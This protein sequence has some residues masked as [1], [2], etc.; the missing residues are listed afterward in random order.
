MS[1]SGGVTDSELLHAIL[2]GA[3]VRVAVVDREGRFLLD[4]DPN[5][6]LPSDSGAPTGASFHALY[7]H[8]PGAAE[9]LRASFDGET[10]RYARHL[11]GANYKATFMPRRTDAG[12]IDRV[13]VVGTL[14]S[15]GDVTQSALAELQARERRIF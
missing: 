7:G 4:P 12:E 13:I 15:D 9:A 1:R 14:I 2:A 8:I 3:P 6:P 11:G 10:I 5:P